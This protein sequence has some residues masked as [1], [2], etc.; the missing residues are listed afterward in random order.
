MRRERL[1]R[2]LM[3]RGFM[4]RGF[5]KKNPGK[6]EGNV[7][8]L[9]STG[10]C[11]LAMCVILLYFFDFVDKEVYNNITS[12]AFLQSTEFKRAMDTAKIRSGI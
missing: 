2:R 12:K 4:G 3:G 8:D 6:Q 1:K 10:F 5:V 9:I 11:I 7:T